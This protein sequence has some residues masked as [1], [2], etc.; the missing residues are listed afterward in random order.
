ME[1]RMSSLFLD[2]S[3]FSLFLGVEMVGLP[4]ILL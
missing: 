4:Q 1:R 2:V 3:S